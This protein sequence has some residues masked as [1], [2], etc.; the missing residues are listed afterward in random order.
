MQEV[1]KEY[2]AILYKLKRAVCTQEDAHIVLSAGRET[3]VDIVADTNMFFKVY[4]ASKI[5]PGRITL[6][7]GP[8]QYVKQIGGDEKWRSKPKRE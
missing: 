2:K 1:S 5:P 8:G 4:V 6:V 3:N 7:Y